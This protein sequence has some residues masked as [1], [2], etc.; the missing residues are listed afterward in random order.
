[1]NNSVTKLRR[2]EWE[3]Q[4][5]TWP[6]CINQGCYNDCACRDWKVSGLPSIRT[7]CSTCALARKKGK[8]RDGV[9]Y[10]KKAYCENRDGH[11]GFLCP[12]DVTLEDWKDPK[13]FS[14]LLEMDH[15]D[16][17]GAVSNNAVENVETLCKLCHGRK[18]M[19]SNDFYSTKKQ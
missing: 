3:K 4:G 9:L 8:M 5:N 12:F 14:H 17:S 13:I 11:L 1:M 19:M 18:G 15:K 16:G 10:H 7:E 6:T 2:L